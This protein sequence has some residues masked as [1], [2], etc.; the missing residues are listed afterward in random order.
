MDKSYIIRVYKRDKDGASASGIVEDVE[1]SKRTR[2]SN[3]N[4]LWSLITDY[5]KEDEVSNVVLLNETLV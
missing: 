3:A 5:T 4:Q 1:G 2:F